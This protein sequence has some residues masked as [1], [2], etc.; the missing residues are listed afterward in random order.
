YNPICSPSCNNGGT[1]TTDEICNC[2]GT[3]FTGKLCDEYY[4]YKNNK[5]VI[6]FFA[7]LNSLII[8][9]IFIIGYYIYWYMEEPII[10]TGKINNSKA[11]TVD[12]IINVVGGIAITQC[13]IMIIGLF[14]NSYYI[15]DKYTNTNKVYYKCQY[16][17]I[18]I[19]ND[20]IKIVTLSFSCVLAYTTK[21]IS[22][23]YKEKLSASVYVYIITTFIKYIFSSY[24]KSIPFSTEIE[25][26][27]MEKYG[28]R[29]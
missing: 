6:A 4:P 26:I 10:K 2:Q 28:L 12:K 22:N 9:I 29:Y 15:T 1:C 8:I 21:S 5:L 18:E 17:N 27:K 20:F 16:P 11:V 13:V 7:T 14:N 23:N 3:K 24:S 25:E 19:I